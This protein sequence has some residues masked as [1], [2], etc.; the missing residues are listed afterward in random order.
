M[1]R[2][3]LSNSHEREK[4][5]GMIPK[6]NVSFCEYRWASSPKKDKPPQRGPCQDNHLMV[7]K[8]SLMRMDKH[9]STN[10]AGSLLYPYE[11]ANFHPTHNG[12]KHQ[13]QTMIEDEGIRG[14]RTV[15]SFQVHIYT[16][17]TRGQQ[18]SSTAEACRSL[19]KRWTANNTKIKNICSLK[20]TMIWASSK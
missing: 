6:S 2:P 12:L 1:C 9:L 7:N 16:L 8:I 3:W 17:I 4:Q 5:N 11:K 20:R 13:G 14:A 10:Y 15:V 19:G 18:R